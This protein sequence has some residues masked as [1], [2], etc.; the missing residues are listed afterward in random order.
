MHPSVEHLHEIFDS[1]GP[2]HTRRMFG[3]YGI[4]HD[5][6]MFALY[7]AGRLYLKTDAHNVADFMAQGCTP[8]TYT[9]RGKPVQLS[10]WCAPEI[11]LD[12]RD[13]ARTWATSAFNAALRAQVAKNLPKKS[14]RVAG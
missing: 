2:I 8:F 14:K 6:I 5:G 4:Y 11:I 12:E 1:F 10:Y 13:Q 7:A 3:G 9:Q